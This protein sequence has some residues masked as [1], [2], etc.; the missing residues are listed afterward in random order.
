[1]KVASFTVH[2]SA[3]QSARWKRAA[4]AEGYASVGTWASRALDAVHGLHATRVYA[5]R[6]TAKAAFMR[7][8]G[9]RLRADFAAENRWSAAGRLWG[10]GVRWPDLAAPGSVYRRRHRGA[11]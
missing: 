6:A 9:K 11:D 1:M 10:T 8:R 3:D 2:A 7:F 5:P 4:E